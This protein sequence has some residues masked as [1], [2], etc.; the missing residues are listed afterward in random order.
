[1]MMLVL[2]DASLGEKGGGEEER[3]REIKREKVS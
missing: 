3:E 1:M 2:Q